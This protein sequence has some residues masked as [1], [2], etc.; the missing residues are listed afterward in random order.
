MSPCCSLCEVVP[1]KPRR[2]DLFTLFTL[3]VP[4]RGRAGTEEEEAELEVEKRRCRRWLN[5][6][7]ARGQDDTPGSLHIY[8]A[9]GVAEVVCVA[10][11]AEPDRCVA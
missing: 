6:L 5:D 8:A 1:T 2:H 9:K 7:V 10:P 4:Q 3:N 11:E